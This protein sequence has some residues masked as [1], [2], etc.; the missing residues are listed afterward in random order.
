FLFARIIALNFSSAAPSA[1]KSIRQRDLLNAWLRLYAR[2]QITP[3]ISEYQ[4]ARLEEELLDLIYYTVDWSSPAPRLTIQSEGTRISRAYGHTGKGV[5]LD[6]YV[7]PQL[8]PFVMPIYHECL[9]RALPVYS[10]ADV[11]DTYG[12][13]VACER[14]LLPFR[15][16]ERV[17]HVIAS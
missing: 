4:P 8:A 7:G 17:S 9:V 10:V 15:T 6:D 13:I 3:S 5:H 12:R 1:V 14:L 11:D 2:Q 16:D